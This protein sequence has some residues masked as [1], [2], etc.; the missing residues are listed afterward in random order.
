MA[1]QRRKQ[2][3]VPQTTHSFFDDLSP[4]TKQAIVAIFFVVLAVFFVFSSLG[5]AGIAGD[6]THRGLK[7]LFGYGFVLAPIV[8]ALFVFVF[9]KP[10]DDNKVSGSKLTGVSLF[11][12]ATLALLHLS[13]GEGGVVGNMLF[14]P[15]HALFGNIVTGVIIV[16]LIIVG[17]FLTFNTNFVNMFQKKESGEE[18]EVNPTITLPPNMPEPE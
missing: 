7:K 3:P 18:E 10:R 6:A 4:H 16:A 11:F 2:V 8:C 17:L 13:M 5:I 9:L 12:I 14:Y 15:L 1:K